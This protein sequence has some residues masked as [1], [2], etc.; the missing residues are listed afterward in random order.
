MS[1]EERIGAETRHPSSWDALD[2]V[3][4]NRIY[5]RA[6]D[7]SFIVVGE[8]PG[9]VEGGSAER[10]SGRPQGRIPSTFGE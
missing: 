3:A 1:A 8:A 6:P 9:L 5:M 4:D 7:G 2:P 10:S